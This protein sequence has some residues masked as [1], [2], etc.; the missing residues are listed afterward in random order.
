MRNALRLIG[1]TVMIFIGLQVMENVAITF[2]LFY[3]WLLFV[4]LIDRA[5]PVEQLKLDKRGVVLGVGSGLLF[6]IF[7]FGGL[8]WLHVYLLDIEYLRTLLMDWG[9][10]GRGEIL[11]VLVLLLANPVLEEL[12]WRGYMFN[13]LRMKGSALYAVGMSAGFYTLYHLLSI[14]PIFEAGFSFVAVLP[15][16]IAGLFWGFIREKSGSMT[17]TIISHVLSDFGIVCVYWFIVR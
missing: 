6:F 8:S 4:P 17:A 7:I 2:L 1:P 3:S 13:R 9:F 10:S 15:V 14:I 11:L 16:F 5:F 12:Y